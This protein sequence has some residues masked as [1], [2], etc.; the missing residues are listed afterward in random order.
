V[1]AAQ[2]ATLAKFVKRNP[3]DWTLARIQILHF[4]SSFAKRTDLLTQHT[5]HRRSVNFLTVFGL[6][7]MLG[8]IRAQM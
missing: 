3:T 8:T 6:Q 5:A 2:A 4:F 1:R 7:V